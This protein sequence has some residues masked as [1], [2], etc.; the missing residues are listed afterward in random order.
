MRWAW[1]ELGLRADNLTDARYPL[2]QFFYASD[3]RSR[4]Y[5]TLAP[6][7]HPRPHTGTR[8]VFSER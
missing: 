1:V 7:A 6:A 5:A 8:R 2:S 3:F 4:D